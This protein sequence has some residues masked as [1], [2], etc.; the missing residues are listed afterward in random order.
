MRPKKPCSF[1]CG[2]NAA[3]TDEENEDQLMRWAYSD[4]SGNND[5]YCERTWFSAD[6]HKYKS[7]ADFQL[8]LKRGA[9]LLTDFKDKRA[10]F[11]E[12]R[13]KGGNVFRPQT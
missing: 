4:G 6:S 1:L 11:I 2:K 8:K 13:R 10:C 3:D 5:W 9:K 7:R 12:S